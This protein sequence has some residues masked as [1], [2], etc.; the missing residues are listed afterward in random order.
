MFGVS[1]KI[2]RLGLFGY[3]AIV[4]L[5][6]VLRLWRGRG[7]EVANAAL[8]VMAVVALVA[9]SRVPRRARRFAVGRGDVHM[10]GA[11]VDGSVSLLPLFERGAVGPLAPS[12]WESVTLRS[13][14]TRAGG[15]RKLEISPARAAF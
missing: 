8:G 3:A 6:L 7:V 2:A 9:A 11:P 13:N 4:S 15:V 12:R 1:L 14:A 5:E 10:G